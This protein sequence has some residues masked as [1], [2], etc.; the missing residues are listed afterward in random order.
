MVL[1]DEVG[2]FSVEETSIAVIDRNGNVAAN[3]LVTDNL[4]L[5][6]REESLPRYAFVAIIE[7]DCF[8]FLQFRECG[9]STSV[10]HHIQVY[11]E[12]SKYQLLPSV[13][14][15]ALRSVL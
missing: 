5:K 10:G 1:A 14:R 4:V 7:G 9:Q 6:P 11:S 2:S 15:T 8:A 13:T 12:R 3:I